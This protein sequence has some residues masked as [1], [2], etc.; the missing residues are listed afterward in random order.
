M[1]LEV[2]AYKDG[3]FEGLFLN[4]VDRISQS[5]LLRTFDHQYLRR[6]IDLKWLCPIEQIL[7]KGLSFANP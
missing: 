6:C 3:F 4:P 2:I 7:L 1:G 5:L